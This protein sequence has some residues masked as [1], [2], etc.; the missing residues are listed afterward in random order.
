[1][2]TEFCISLIAA[3]F[4]GL[5]APGF[6]QGSMSRYTASAQNTLG[7]GKTLSSP[8][9]KGFTIS[10]Q[11]RFDQSVVLT[12]SS[13]TRFWFRDPSGTTDSMVSAG[14]YENT[15]L[16]AKASPARPVLVFADNG[17][18]LNARG[19]QFSLRSLECSTVH[20]I[21]RF[22]PDSAQYDE[23]QLAAWIQSNIRFVKV[24]PAP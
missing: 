3:A 9:T 8:S 22:D 19:G 1:M 12:V 13:A 23:S 17:R 24:N 11:R 5:A 10:A 16:W 20:P 2:K 21:P 15:S 14:R 6:S 7:R 4:L 18:P